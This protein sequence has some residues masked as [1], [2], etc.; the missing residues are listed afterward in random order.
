MHTSNWLQG[1]PF[2]EVSF[3]WE[4]KED[5][6]Q[7]IYT[8]IRKLSAL[9]TSISIVDVNVEKL[10]EAF[11]TGYPYDEEDPL[12]PVV[13]SL[14]L[15]LVAD[16][17]GTRKAILQVE[18][19][20]ANALLVDFWFFGSRFDALQWDQIGIKNKDLAA[21]TD[22][23][24][25]LYSS[26]GF[27]VGGIALEKDIR[28]LFDCDEPSPSPCYQFENLSPDSSLEMEPDFFALVWN[29]NCGKLRD[30]PAQHRRIGK[31]GVLVVSSDSY[32][33][34]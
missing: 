18:Q 24:A 15:K 23:L 30:M 14:E 27:K 4:L 3:L 13:H 31:S 29:E 21:F 16:I 32:S 9:S 7:A 20:S 34:F 2:L 10:I 6:T 1:G 33:E 25:D 8:L 22:F 19:L 11:E 17:A 12:S 5:R 28:E 26:F